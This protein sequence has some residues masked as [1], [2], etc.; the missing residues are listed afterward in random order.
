MFVYIDSISIPYSHRHYI[1]SYA[2]SDPASLVRGPRTPRGSRTD[3]NVCILT[4][5][6]GSVRPVTVPQ[7]LYGYRVLVF[8]R[9][10]RFFHITVVKSSRQLCTIAKSLDKGP[11]V[12]AKLAPFFCGYI[13]VPS[14]NCRHRLLHQY[15]TQT[16]ELSQQGTGCC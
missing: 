10:R 4:A 1:Y 12:S 3:A 11:C 14:V 2:S 16:P 13:L 6:F 8:R 5:G 15:T 9:S 7:V